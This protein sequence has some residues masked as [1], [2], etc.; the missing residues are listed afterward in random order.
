LRSAIPP[1]PLSA[2]G[3]VQVTVH[4]SKQ[5]K[6]YLKTHKSIKATATIVLT[7]NGTSKTT[8]QTIT[9]KAPAKKHK[10]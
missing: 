10:K 3:T 2:H 8:I 6:A 5:A 9:V 1:S 7:A 4:L